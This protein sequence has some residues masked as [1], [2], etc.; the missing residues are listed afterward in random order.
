VGLLVASSCPSYWWNQDEY[1][2]PAVLLQAYRWE[3]L[4]AGAVLIEESCWKDSK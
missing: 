1:L 4:G 2:G 3:T